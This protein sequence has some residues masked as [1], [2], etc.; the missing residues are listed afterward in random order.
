L[1][2]IVISGAFGP[3]IPRVARMLGA[4]AA[5]GKPVEI[6]TL[7]H[8]VRRFSLFEATSGQLNPS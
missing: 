5:L 3:E 8:T 1:K 2:I 7:F 4:A 6:E